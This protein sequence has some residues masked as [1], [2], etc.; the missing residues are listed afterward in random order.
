MLR[1]LKGR[2]LLAW[3]VGYLIVTV[4]LANLLVGARLA[5]AGTATGLVEYSLYVLV[6]GILY[7]AG[8][9]GIVRTGGRIVAS[10]PEARLVNFLLTMTIAFVLFASW[11][12]WSVDSLIAK[13]ILDAS[14]ATSSTNM[15]RGL[16]AVLSNH[17][18][19]ALPLLLG[20]FVITL[21]PAER[22]IEKLA[23]PLN[24]VLVLPAFLFLG[25]HPAPRYSL[26]LVIC[27]AVVV[28][29]LVLFSR[30]RWL[31]NT[32]T[33]LVVVLSAIS[34]FGWALPA[35]APLAEVPRDH[36]ELLLHNNRLGMEILVPERPASTVDWRDRTLRPAWSKGESSRDGQL[37]VL[38][39][40]DMARAAQILAEWDQSRILRVNHLN[41]VDMEAWFLPSVSPRDTLLEQ[42]LARGRTSASLTLGDKVLGMS[43]AEMTGSNRAFAVFNG[44]LVPEHL[45]VLKAHQ[46]LV[47]HD[48]KVDL[49]LVM[50]AL[51]EQFGAPPQ[52]RLSWDSLLGYQVTLWQFPL[53]AS[54]AQGERLPLLRRLADPFHWRRGRGL[55]GPQ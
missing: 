7:L 54:E 9:V 52:R 17:T 43:L 48:H 2:L 29:R 55:L 27:T 35:T 36:W 38:F 39:Q 32:A 49:E 34:L 30:L 21:L 16:L 12:V 1:S 23:W 47:L 33:V 20:G 40:L 24:L 19:F 11:A 15:A 6:P 53:T 45:L 44:G 22:T 14:P 41:L 13:A 28:A 5:A 25:A 46:F 31:R 4:V 8:V 51:V 37:Y 3:S 26:A 10:S 18:A 50:D 42:T